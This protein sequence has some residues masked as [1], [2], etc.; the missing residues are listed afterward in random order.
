[1]DDLREY[2]PETDEAALVEQ[3]KSEGIEVEGIEEKPVEEE[4]KAEPAEEVKEETEEEPA[5]EE[6][7]DNDDDLVDERTKKGLIAARQKEREKRRAVEA[8][9]NAEIARLNKQLEELTK[10]RVAPIQQAVV[11]QQPQTEQ[12]G[13]FDEL[14]DM[15]SEQ[16]RKESGIDK[17]LT[18]D[19]IATLQFT[20]PRK[21]QKYILAMNT[22]AQDLHQ[23]YSANNALGKEI[24]SEPN[25]EAL[26]NYAESQLDEL[27]RREARKIDEAAAAFGQHKATRE[28]LSLLRDYWGKAKAAFN[29]ARQPV[30][31][32]VQQPAI[33]QPS[34]L[35][36]FAKQPRSQ[37]IRGSQSSTMSEADLLRMF[38]DDPEGALD[39]VPKAI[40][41]RYRRG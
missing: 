41:D 36:N 26:L 31:P 18:D 11:A 29:E 34:K 33:Q 2:F 19:D 27:P 37:E 6:D 32:R 4:A 13:Y 30:Q 3:A 24:A 9:K 1:M 10:Q 21:Y 15:A 5:K 12:Q 23:T 28:Q 35:D 16:A 40:L 20:E 7:T 17:T 38:D 25:I 14:M 22:I 8:E 39:K